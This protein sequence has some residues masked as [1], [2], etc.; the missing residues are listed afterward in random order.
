M[1]TKIRKWGALLVILAL[2]VPM[3]MAAS[4]FGADRK[5][6]PEEVLQRIDSNF[7]RCLEVLNK[8]L[9]KVPEEAKE[10]IALAISKVER[11]R[12]FMAG[13]IIP[14]GGKDP[15]AGSLE[16]PVTP[17]ADH[18]RPGEGPDVVEPGLPKPPLLYPDRRSGQHSGG[19]GGYRAPEIP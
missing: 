10:A 12:K 7:Q 9:E 8:A 16:T 11:W 14:M 15:M 19:M 2:L 3:F 1:R 18:G 5:P 17:G 13:L 6:T 4:A